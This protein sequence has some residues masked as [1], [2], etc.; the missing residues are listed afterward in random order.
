MPQ[1]GEQGDLKVVT[2]GSENRA[3]A[4]PTQGGVTFPQGRNGID[5]PS[6][7]A[8]GSSNS[9]SRDAELVSRVLMTVNGESL[10]SKS[11]ALEEEP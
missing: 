11:R 2:E 6:S 4:A 7:E 3:P 8:L 5:D 1:R 9:A 10:E